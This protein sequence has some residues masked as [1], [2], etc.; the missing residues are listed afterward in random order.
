MQLSEFD[1]PFDPSLIAAEPVRPRDCARLLL[2]ERQADRLV[3]RRVADLPCLLRQGDLLVV[4]DT[5]VL[6]ARVSGIKQPTGTPVDV[7]FVRDLGEG[8]WEM[9]VKG[10]FRIGQVI[11]FDPQS[12]ATIVKRD[13]T[14]TEVVVDGPVPVTRLFESQGV[15]PLP[16]YI[17]RASTRDDHRWYQTIFAKHAGAIAAPTAG[18]HFTEK[19][20]GWLHDAG[21]H[22]SAVTLH[23]GPG[24]FKPVTT[25]RIEDHQMGAETFTLSDETAKAIQETKRAGGR[26]VAVGT[27]VVR[28]LET[29]ANE[30]GKIVSMSGESRLFITPGFQFKVVDA[31]MTNFH[32]PR[33][34][35]LMLVSA[36]AGIEPI[37]RAYEEA[38]KER[39]RFYSYGDAMLIL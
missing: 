26:V 6:A 15:M 19:L 12:R 10:T 37:R 31:L 14:G 24:T 13:V 32:L 33:T 16:P 29:V 3:H 4:N 25:E 36:F 34:T 22:V 28:T 18:L 30:R 20:L 2:L 38:V 9:M 1:F 39:Y 35:L 27:T 21:I 5:K 7:L 17:K 23:V 8:R 11:E